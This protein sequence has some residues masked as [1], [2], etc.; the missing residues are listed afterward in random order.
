MG[1]PAQGHKSYMQFGR[2]AAYGTGVAATHRLGFV[3]SSVEP[4]LGFVRDNTLNDAVVRS[5]IYPVGQFARGQIEMVLDYAGLL[6]LFDGVFGTG[7]FGS[8]GG[9]TTGAGPYTHVF[10]EKSLLN[11]YTIELIEG[12]VPAN[13]CQRL[14]GAKIVGMTV[15]GEAGQGDNALVRVIWDIIAKEK[16]TDQT[17]TGALTAVSRTSVLFHQATTVDDGTADSSADVRLRSFELA[18]VSPVA[19]DRFY[20]GS[21]T[22]DEPLRSDFVAPTLRLVKEFQTK[23]LIDAFKAGTS[24]SPQ[25]VFTSG[26]NVITIEMGT[27]KATAYTH[28][29]SGYGIVTQEVTWEGLQTAGPPVYGVKFTVVNSQATIVT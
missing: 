8:T 23:T 1:T 14:I 11:S 16:Q 18:L 29:V 19:E 9:T 3:S 25:L 21:T 24:G 10:T 12:N 28:P 6:L 17:P 2:E 13:K 20:F 27:A 26:T 4:V 5:A 15:R 22:I 7:T